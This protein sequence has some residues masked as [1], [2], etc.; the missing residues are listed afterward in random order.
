MRSTRPHLYFIFL[1]FEVAILQVVYLCRNIVF[2]CRSSKPFPYCYVSCEA[3]EPP[4]VCIYEKGRYRT[5]KELEQRQHAGAISAVESCP[6]K[7]RRG[8]R[9]MYRRRSS[10]TKTN[11]LAPCSNSADDMRWM[12]T[13]PTGSLGCE[14]GT[15]TRSVKKI[16]EDA[17]IM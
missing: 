17:F 11:N 3:T 14:L 2:K 5:R 13:L 1:V 6:Q 15:A 4:E 8:G 9:T 12:G 7:R 16:V 10:E